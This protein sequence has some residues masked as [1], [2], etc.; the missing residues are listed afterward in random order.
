[1]TR[2][3]FV[4][5]TLT[6]YPALGQDGGASGGD[7]INLPS[8][9]A[10]QGE[11]GLTSRHHGVERAYRYVRPRAE[12]SSGKRRPS[13]PAASPRHGQDLSHTPQR[14]DPIGPR[15]PA[16]WRGWA[17][18]LSWF[19]ADQEEAPAPREAQKAAA[20]GG[21]VSC[22]DGVNLPAWAESP[23]SDD[24]APTTAAGPDLPDVPDP[25]PVDGGLGLLLLAGAG[26]AVRRLRS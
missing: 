5:L 6:A 19:D 25:V 23:L 8:W 13:K 4:L 21:A 7:G 22:S 15:T 11:E 10:P 24:P 14:V 1:M 20:C 9:A 12:R 26:Y 17:V 18:F 16:G 3:A 2:Y